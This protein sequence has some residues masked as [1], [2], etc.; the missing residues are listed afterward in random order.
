MRDRRVVSPARGVCFFLHSF[1]S[2][3]SVVYSTWPS[4]YS[5][6]HEH[7]CSF[8]YSFYL[9]LLYFCTSLTISNKHHCS[10]ERMPVDC[11]LR[12]YIVCSFPMLSQSFAQQTW[13]TEDSCQWDSDPGGRTPTGVV[14]QN[15][16]ARWKT[17]LPPFYPWYKNVSLLW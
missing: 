10:D 4:I 17:H 6:F 2:Q 1:I 15:I 16:H 13:T 5:L 9:V 14:F 12:I 3:W 7:S 11:S 8:L